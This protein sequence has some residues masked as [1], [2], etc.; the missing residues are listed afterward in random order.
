[1]KLV[2]GLDLYLLH[3]FDCQLIEPEAA[4]APGGLRFVVQADLPRRCC[5]GHVSLLVM[6]IQTRILSCMMILVFILGVCN[7]ILQALEVVFR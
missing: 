6:D 1:M 7:Y 2:I 5:R 3:L 4:L